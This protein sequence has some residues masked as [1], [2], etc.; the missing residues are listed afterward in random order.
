MKSIE[1]AILLIA[2][3]FT[4]L[5]TSCT[6]KV[7]VGEVFWCDEEYI[8]LDI[9]SDTFR[10]RN[11]NNDAIPAGDSVLIWNEYDWSF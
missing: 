5:F 8:Y 6:S 1:K 9:E 3:F 11:L 7:L 10:L 4:L 2:V